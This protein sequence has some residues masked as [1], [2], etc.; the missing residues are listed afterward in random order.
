MDEQEYYESEGIALPK[1]SFPGNEIILSIFIFADYGL[2]LYISFNYCDHYQLDLLDHKTTGIFQQLDNECKI[3]NPN[4]ERFMV[5][6]NS[7]HAYSPA[8]ILNHG[9][10]SF[11]IKHFSGKVT[12]QTVR[13][14]SFK[15]NNI[16]TRLFPLLKENFLTNN[17]EIYPA[18]VRKLVEQTI[19]PLYSKNTSLISE[20]STKKTCGENFRT[21]LDSLL[22]Q[23][24]Q[25]VKIL[26][27]FHS[28]ISIVLQKL[29][30]FLKIFS[31]ATI[32]SLH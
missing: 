9:Q 13:Q 6:V 12:Y 4:L 15:Q 14:I 2:C 7:T 19:H 8:F 27:L 31:A 20:K 18:S 32:Y 25:T 10:N 24:K 29:L 30:N 28:F 1:I 17:T 21:E 26:F 16:L 11:T 22:L 5:N 3:P 23:L